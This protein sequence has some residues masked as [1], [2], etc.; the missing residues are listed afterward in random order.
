MI[1]RPMRRL[2]VL[3][4]VLR[5]MVFADPLFL[6]RWGYGHEDDASSSQLTECSKHACCAT[7]ALY[8]VGSVFPCLSTHVLNLCAVQGA[9]RELFVLERAVLGDLSLLGTAWE[10]FLLTRPSRRCN[11]EPCYEQNTGKHAVTSAA[12]PKVYSSPKVLPVPVPC[13]QMY[14]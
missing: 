11:Y 12:Q 2:V 8:I 5:I 4:P 9:V 3:C 10:I 6:G 7:N 1:H 14:K 13:L